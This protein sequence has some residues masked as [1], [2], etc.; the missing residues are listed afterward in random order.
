[1]V[2]GLLQPSELQTVCKYVLPTTKW[3]S[4]TS[5]VVWGALPSYVRQLLPIWRQSVR[6]IFNFQKFR[7]VIWEWQWYV[8]WHIVYLIWSNCAR[9]QLIHKR[10]VGPT[11]ILW[12]Y[13]CPSV[14][15]RYCVKTAK[16]FHFL[17]E[18]PI[19]VVFVWVSTSCFRFIV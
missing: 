5:W 3:L 1:M 4:K 11:C 9:T 19:T 14:T 15:A 13:V 16:S 7:S 2:N 18:S 8:F 6:R 10:T 17:K 12:H